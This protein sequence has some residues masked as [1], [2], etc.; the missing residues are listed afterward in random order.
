MKTKRFLSVGAFIALTFGL[1]LISV[2]GVSAEDPRPQGIPFSTMPWPTARPLRVGET[3]SPSSA[4]SAY[5]PPA[6]SSSIP[7]IVLPSNPA[8]VPSP[9]APSIPVIVIPP[10]PAPAQSNV[11]PAN[12]PP[13]VSSGASPSNALMAAGS[14]ETLGAGAAVWYRIGNGGVHMDVF[15]DAIPMSNVSMQVFAPNQFHKPIGYGTLSKDGA[16][17]VWAGGHWK[18]Q[19]DWVAKITNGNPIPISYRL[20]SSA[21]DISN[22]SCYSYWEWIGP[23]YVYWTECR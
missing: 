10:N 13:P 14:W 19:G 11:L 7:V 20:T 18:S 1:L 23:N 21:I 22:K 17:L 8:P 15:L 12:N 2:T 16:R 6:A 9:V 5:N 4:P 3:W